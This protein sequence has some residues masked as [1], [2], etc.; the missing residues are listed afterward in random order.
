MAEL[1]DAHA[2]GACILTDVEV[3]LLFPA[4]M[5]GKYLLIL[6]TALFLAGI[7]LFPVFRPAVTNTDGTDQASEQKK[8]I[9]ITQKITIVEQ[10][11]TSTDI[12]QVQEGEAAL[13][14]LARTKKIEAKEYSFGKAVESIEGVKNGTGGRFWIYYVNDKEMQIGAGEY[15]VQ[16]NDTIEWKFK[17]ENEK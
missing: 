12:I 9:S 6:C 1:A 13:D 16:P 10:Q 4:Q 14:V 17:L 5:K 15:V 7:L 3:Q 11:K 8:K 2:S